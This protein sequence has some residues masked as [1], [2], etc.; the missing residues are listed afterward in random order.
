MTSL[1]KINVNLSE[2]RFYDLAI[3]SN[4]AVPQWAR[5]GHTPLFH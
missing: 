1:C 5:H 2:I 4:L 3:L